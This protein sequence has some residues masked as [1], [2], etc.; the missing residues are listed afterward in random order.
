VIIALATTI[1]I[2]FPFCLPTCA[3]SSL[4]LFFS[5]AQVAVA[6]VMDGPDLEIIVADMGG[7]LACVS[8]NG[9]VLWDLQVG[10]E[11]FVGLTDWCCS[12]Q[13]EVE[14]WGQVVTLAALLGSCKLVVAR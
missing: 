3:Y 11:G 7:T 5:Q 14:Y 1:T 12:R 9:D 2:T 4:S 6:D 10:R 13:V 8:V